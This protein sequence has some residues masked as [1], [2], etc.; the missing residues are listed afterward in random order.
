MLNIV[1]E[2]I[3]ASPSVKVKFVDELEQYIKPRFEEV[4][5]MVH[6]KE[7]NEESFMLEISKDNA[8][9]ILNGLS[10]GSVIQ[11]SE[12]MNVDYSKLSDLL[13]KAKYIKF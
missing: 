1:L 13:S 12:D 5:R 3:S 8:D 10:L 2:L 11:H 7:V 6:L 4:Q 9:E